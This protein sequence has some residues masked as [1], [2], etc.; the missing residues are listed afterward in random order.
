MVLVDISEIL[1]VMAA[2]TCAFGAETSRVSGSDLGVSPSLI[3]PASVAGESQP[4]L[5]LLRMPL[6][7]TG[8]TAAVVDPTATDESDPL[9]VAF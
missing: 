6:I 4:C 7:D 9:G 5:A 3:L 2:H 8:G 1:A